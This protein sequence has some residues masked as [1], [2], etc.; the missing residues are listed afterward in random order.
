MAPRRARAAFPTLLLLFA[1]APGCR[2]RAETGAGYNVLLISLDST[3]RDLLGTYG[4]DAPHAPGVPSSPNLDALAAEGIRMT[5]A[6]ATT[7]WTLPSHMTLLTGQPELVHAVELDHLRPDPERRTLASVLRARG[8]ATSGFYTGPYLDPRFGFARGFDR[9]EACFGPELA[10]ATARMEA[11]SAR[12]AA[13]QARGDAAAQRAAEA[14]LGRAL[15]EVD[16]LSHRDRSSA[17]VADRSID[18]IEAAHAAGEPFFVFAHFF[19]PHYDYVPPPEHDVF[20]PGYEGAVT[21]DDFWTNPAISTVAPTPSGR[22]R[23][24]DDRGLEHVRA[25]YAGELRWTD[26]QVGRLLGRLDALDVAERTL[27]I[28]TSDHGDELFEHGAIGHRRTL[29]EEVTRIPLILRMPGVLPRGSAAE[30]LVSNVDV[31]P[32]V[33]D[34]LGLPGLPGTYGRS[35]APLLRNAADEGDAEERDVLARLITVRQGS[36][37]R[38]GGGEPIPAQLVA[39]EE[40]FRVGRVKVQRRREWPEPSAATPRDEVARIEAQAR[41]AREQE[42]LR[43]ID[44]VGFPEEP[45]GAWSTSFPPGA[46]RDAL[47]AFHDRYAEL[48]RE[49]HAA[50]TAG[51]GEPPIP[52]MAALGY[53]DGAS[54]TVTSERFVLP[55]P[56]AELLRAE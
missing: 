8:Y 51:A 16:G 31:L 9:Y 15:A 56:G 32:T 26:A 41:T 4:H 49:R 54:A 3:R 27:V 22:R 53:A 45:E 37:G 48:L 10:A 44:V 30:G 24:V 34:L 43:W 5:E 38:A 23:V 13:V 20:D 40:T 17:T 21:G 12:A 2:D 55:P 14:D 52:G 18:A 25:L 42:T 50:A 28:V 7:S 46:A 47:R 36:L 11:A 35:F 1:L 39:V 19:D 33:L 29:Y 6:Y